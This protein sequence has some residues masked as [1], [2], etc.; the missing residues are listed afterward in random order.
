M[1]SY[2]D[3][4]RYVFFT[5]TGEHLDETQVNES[6]YY[7]GE[8]KNHKVYLYYRPDVEFL[9]NAP[10]NKTFAEE[11]LG[12]WQAGYKTRLVIGSHKYLDDDYLHDHHIEFCQLPFA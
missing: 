1:P 2:L 11:R 8:S 4:A 6:A 7:L 12:K 5:A 9:K 3:L 10:L